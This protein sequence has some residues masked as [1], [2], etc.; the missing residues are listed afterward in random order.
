VRVLHVGKFYPPARGG[1]EQVLRLLAEGERQHVD[2]AVLV[3][4][5]RWRTSRETS[6]G[7]RVTRAGC[8]GVVGSAGVCPTFPYHLARAKADV[9]VV[10]EPNPL[11]LLSYAVARPRGRLVVWLHSELIEHR[12]YYRFYRPLLAWGVRRAAAIVVSSARLAEHADTLRS[13]RDKCVVV[14]LGIDAERFVPTEETERRAHALRA[15]YGA[16]FVLFVGRLVPYKGVDVLLDALAGSGIPAVIVGSGPLEAALRRRCEA[17][18]LCDGVH[19]VGE[20]SDEDLAALYRACAVLVLPSIARN[21]AFGLVQLEAMACARPVVSTDLPTGVP[22]VNQHGRTGLVVPP[23]DPRALRAALRRLLADPAL[24]EKLGEDGRRRVAREFTVP[25]MVRAT[26][27][28][29]R[30]LAA[31]G[32]RA[33]REPVPKRLFDAAL[34]G[35]GLLAALPVFAVVSA[36]IKLEDGGPVFYRQRRIGRG[37][38]EF[39]IVKFR[40]MRP[41]SDSRFGPLA[42][43]E[44]DAR[45]TRIGRLLRAT[46][47]DE[48]PQLWNIFR[49]DMSFVGPRALMPE[50]IECAGTGEPEPLAKIAGYEARH[51]VRP[52][53]TGVAQIYADRDVR[54]RHKFRYD[55]LYIRRQSFWLDVRLILLSFWITARGRW[56]HRG[57]KV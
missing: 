31:G 21:E 52:G 26:T 6:A 12:W 24:R 47:M 20:V 46:A 2:V 40:S 11:G 45:I 37:A 34:A 29:Y 54:R 57:K 49:G 14:P 16:S 32:P 36:A 38:R 42:A 39:G 4:G 28:L 27:A 3:A 43:R 30:R 35:V 15:R 18:G 7:V 41:D 13:V 1:M 10:H 8:L 55:L 48:L 33:A 22:W 50:E 51:A 19:F 5:T 53:L 25:G 9:V 56:E 23:G 17:L 44:S